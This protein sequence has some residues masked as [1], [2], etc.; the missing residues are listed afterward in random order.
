MSIF[1][2]VT[3]AE[4]QAFRHAKV[5][6]GTSRDLAKGFI[7]C[8]LEHQVADIWRKRYWD[9]PSAL[10]TLQGV[11]YKLEGGWPHVYRPLHMTDVRDIVQIDALMPPDERK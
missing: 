9:A 7:C 6:R 3:L 8:S 11:E 2:F 10:L 1:K 5:F 4:W